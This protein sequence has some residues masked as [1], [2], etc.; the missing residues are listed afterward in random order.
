MAKI[1]KILLCFWLA[2]FCVFY[3]FPLILDFYIGSSAVFNHYSKSFLLMISC[4]IS[5]ILGCILSF[6]LKRI[7]LIVCNLTLFNSLIYVFSFLCIINH[8]S[9]YYFF[10]SDF[11]HH[12]R[13]S[14]LGIFGYF[15]MIEH[16]AIIPFTILLIKFCGRYFYLSK[17]NILLFLYSLTLIFIPFNVFDLICGLI[18]ISLQFRFFYKFKLTLTSTLLLCFPFLLLLITVF[19]KIKGEGVF[20]NIDV[21]LKYFQYRFSVW[22]ASSLILYEMN[23]STLFN[24]YVSSITHDDSINVSNAELVFSNIDAFVNTRVGASPGFFGSS[25]ILLPFPLNLIIIV[26]FVV[27]INISIKS[28]FIIINDMPILTFL[29]LLVL[30]SPMLSVISYFSFELVPIFKFTLVIIVS[31]LKFNNFL[32]NSYHE[33]I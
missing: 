20:T 22:Y 5:I 17:K 25:L 15:Y 2:F 14:D 26:F 18:L 9:I 30:Y 31:T 10:G 21:F 7:N 8:I 24:I 13:I 11:R 16:I 33:K 28:L 3:F 32:I 19:Y 29:S 1:D 27:I 4:F 23:W 12:M 6:K